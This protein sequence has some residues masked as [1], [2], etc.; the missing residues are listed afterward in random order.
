MWKYRF[1]SQNYFRKLECLKNQATKKEQIQNN[2][3]LN[4]SGN[5]TW[6]T[7]IFW[8]SEFENYYLT[9][10][11]LTQSYA[12]PSTRLRPLSMTASGVP[13][14][15]S[16]RMIY[17]VCQIMIFEKIKLSLSLKDLRHSI[18]VSRIIQNIILNLRLFGCLVLLTFW[19]FSE[20]K[21]LTYPVVG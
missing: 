20:I 19:N 4:S 1:L 11:W 12:R 5:I 9:N 8:D 16:M 17:T 15:F 7:Q 2:V 14:P 18:Y 21:Q 10:S 6:T 3:V 13:P